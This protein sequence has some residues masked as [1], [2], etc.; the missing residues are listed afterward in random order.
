MVE[1][2]FNQSLLSPGRNLCEK[3]ANNTAGL[4]QAQ[5]STLPRLYFDHRRGYYTSSV[6]SSLTKMATNP[7]DVADSMR[8]LQIA[9]NLHP[10]QDQKTQ[11]SKPTYVTALQDVTRAL[12]EASGAISLQEQNIST[13]SDEA[14]PSKTLSMKEIYSLHSS[15]KVLSI[16]AKSLA[17]S[18]DALKD[19][20][21][22]SIIRKLRSLGRQSVAE[23]SEKRGLITKLFSHFD[24]R[25]R[26]T[27]YV[28]LDT[29]SNHNLLWKV[30]EECYNEASSE[31]GALHASNY[32][33]TQ[34]E[35]K[36]EHKSQG[37]M[38]KE[39]TWVDHWL[40]TLN[41]A[42][43]GPTLFYPP[44]S[45]NR[46]LVFEEPSRYLF[47]TF[48]S[49]SSGTS[50]E[51]VIASTASVSRTQERGR[52]DLLGIRKNEAAELLRLH[53][54]KGLFDGY[55]TDNLMSWTSSLIFAIQYAIR[56]S[57]WRETDDIKI[58]VV[59]TRKYPQGQF[60]RDTWLIEYFQPIDQLPS[61]AKTCFQ[62]CLSYPDYYNGE[63]FSQ[64]AVSIADRSCVTSLKLMEEAGL[65]KLYPEF[66][67]A[68]GKKQWANRVR[69]LRREWSEERG[70][71]KKE[72]KLALQVARTCFPQLASVDVA[73][74]LLT[75][76]NRKLQPWALSGK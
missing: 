49:G 73:T 17:N 1:S 32:F 43:N 50:N 48:D 57:E 8:D 31:F 54:K 41:S 69:D 22:G 18:V 67:D 76:R 58:C 45:L 28:L 11:R 40:T 14:I 46:S 53:M 68:D 4:I 56:R 52:T 2:V 29:T 27:I 36:R 60:A 59:D 44:T 7:S 9:D 62:F 38:E 6:P 23:D 70:T 21:E 61:L 65:F 39:Q 63:Y 37:R 74:A 26:H 16:A 25:I 66:Q 75:F 5:P 15:S 3:E 72:M 10:D 42:P 20:T 12:N 35:G 64:G 13:I 47:R 33:G 55:T 19:T 30:A 24:K 51:N 71:S 34:E